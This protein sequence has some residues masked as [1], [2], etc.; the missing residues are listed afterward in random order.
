MIT[1]GFAC[2]HS[3]QV[4]ETAASAPVCPCGETQVTRTQARAPRFV[5]TCT[6]PYA[7]TK[8]LE[9]GVV[10]VAAGGPLTLTQEKPSCR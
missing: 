10:N 7:E 5:G 9:P 8:A 1:V 4:K 2:G 6:G 3:A